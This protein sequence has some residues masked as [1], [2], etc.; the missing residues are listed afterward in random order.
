LEEL[1]VNWED[2]VGVTSLDTDSEEVVDDLDEGVGDNTH[3]FH[4]E[5]VE[6]VFSF[7]DGND[8]L[9][10]PGSSGL[11][12][13]NLGSSGGSQVVELLVVDVEGLGSE[14]TEVAGSGLFVFSEVELGLRC[15]P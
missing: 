11:V 8:G 15:V 14:V 13:S 9:I 10:D 4:F 1:V 5:F 3:S 2:V 7:V 6:D 12:F